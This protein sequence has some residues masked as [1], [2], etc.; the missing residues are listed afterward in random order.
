MAPSTP[1]EPKTGTLGSLQ[2]TR[3]LVWALL[4]SRTLS[5][6]DQLNLALTNKHMAGIVDIERTRLNVIDVPF[7]FEDSLV[8]QAIECNRPDWLEYLLGLGDFTSEGGKE[9]INWLLLHCC[10]HSDDEYN[11]MNCTRG[12]HQ[13]MELCLRFDAVR[14]LQSLIK[15]CDETYFNYDPEWLYRKAKLIAWKERRVQ[16]LSFLHSHQRSNGEPLEE[17]WSYLLTQARN[18]FHVKAL[19]RVMAPDTD[20]FPYLVHHC[21]RLGECSPFVLLEL[22]KRMPAERLTEQVNFRG[23]LTTVLSIASAGLRL[24]SIKLLLGQGGIKRPFEH[25]HRDPARGFLSNPLFALLADLSLPYSGNMG[26]SC[27]ES[28]KDWLARAQ[29]MTRD[30]HTAVKLFKVHATEEFQFELKKHME[31]N[32][33]ACTLLIDRLRDWFIDVVRTN[34]SSEDQDKLLEWHLPEEDLALEW[35]KGV[36]GHMLRSILNSN[37]LNLLDQNLVL[38]WDL[39][40]THEIEQ[41]AESLLKS[42]HDQICEK[43][44]VPCMWSSVDYL[45]ALIAAPERMEAAEYQ[46]IMKMVSA[47]SELPDLDLEEERFGRI[48][49]ELRDHR[50]ESRLSCYTVSPATSEAGELGP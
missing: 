27:S 3:D 46:D 24:S 22:I 10:D 16:G 35:R 50:A 19:A 37:H 47:P 25:Y 41:E 15:F 13:L 29:E 36:S 28:P 45:Y 26:F 38:V 2:R 44:E 23:M 31:M 8:K 20:Y 7:E 4:R 49:Q 14:C 9:S 42:T 5:A 21:G 12:T 32:T 30:L 43:V 33:M 39:L 17:L 18:S 1:S 34:L 48:I 6:E 11:Q 40:R